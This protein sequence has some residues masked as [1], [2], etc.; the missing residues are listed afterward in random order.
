MGD[1]ELEQFKADINLIELASSYGYELVKREC[2]RASIVMLHPDGDKVVIATAADGHGIFFSVRDNR[3]SGS[4]IDFVMHRESANLGVARLI[5]RNWLRPGR[6][7]NQI[8]C[9]KP[10]VISS[11][12]PALYTQWL[13]MRPYS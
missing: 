8:H 11:N 10:E 1:N 5:L 13:R 6:P 7:Q 2:S 9:F 3:C 4:V 12:M